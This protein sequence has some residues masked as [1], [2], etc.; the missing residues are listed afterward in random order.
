MARPVDF[1]SRTRAKNLAALAQDDFDLLVI[2]GGITGAGIVR[3]A[4]LRGYRVALVERRDFAAGT[5]SRSSKLVH[6]GLRFLHEGGL[7]LVM[8]AAHERRGLGPFVAPP[9]G[10][11]PEG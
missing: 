4:A 1:S 3:D 8:E 10:A 5:G 11:V 9:A 7:A 2:G 6:G